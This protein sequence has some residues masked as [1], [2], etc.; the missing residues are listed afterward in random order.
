MPPQST[1]LPLN[2]ATDALETRYGL[3]AVV[4][5]CHWAPSNVHVSVSLV[6]SPPNSTTPAPPLEVIPLLEL[7]LPLVVGPPPGPELLPDTEPALDPAGLPEPL[8]AVVAPWPPA[9]VPPG[10]V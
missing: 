8:T 9:P 7:E 10:S 4:S 2:V 3:V 5:A 6:A 1:T